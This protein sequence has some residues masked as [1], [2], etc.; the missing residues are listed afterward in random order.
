MMINHIPHTKDYRDKL[1]RHAF[2]RYTVRSLNAISHLAVHHSLTKTGSAEAFAQYHVKN[3]AWPGIGYHFVIEKDGTI[4]WCNDLEVSGYHVGNSNRFSVGICLVGDFREQT[5]EAVQ[6]DPLLYLLKFLCR[7]LFILPE[8]VWGHNE[9]PDYAWKECPC[10]NM[11]SIRQSLS[12]KALQQEQTG[13][14]L[15]SLI[16]SREIVM[17][18]NIFMTKPGETVIEVVRHLNNIDL[19]EVIARNKTIDVHEPQPEPVNVK[20]KGPVENIPIEVKQLIKIVEKEGHMVFKSDEKP[21]NLNI[22]GIRSSMTKPNAF[23]DEICVFWKYESIWNLKRYKATTD[24][25]LTYL[26]DP[27]NRKGTAILKEGQYRAT[28]RIGLHKNSYTALVQAK[29]VTVIRDFDRNP[30]INYESG[31]EQTG[32]FGI[33]IHRSSATGESTMVDRWS[34]G[35]Q[36][37][38][39]VHQ[40]DEFIKLC[41]L[42]ASY[43]GELFTYTLISDR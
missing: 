40:Y 41:K 35:C 1:P 23:D 27:M 8:H 30:V 17:D 25:G 15:P 33:N 32:F 38:A 18:P 7:E 37:F 10:L 26:L 29:P 14:N 34:A 19:G 13:F 42:A 39:N 43:W 9:F 21:Y 36:V 2:K 16:G 6:L 4:E 28:Y 11:D 12:K 22:V 24:P 31:V 5:L 3:N 20:I